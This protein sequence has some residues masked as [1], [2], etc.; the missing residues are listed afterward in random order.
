VG[1]SRPEGHGEA[2]VKT[3]LLTR[4]V[5]GRLFRHYLLFAAIALVVVSAVQFLENRDGLLD[6]PGTTLLDVLRHALLAAPGLFS[7]LAGFIALVSTL[8]ALVTLADHGELRTMLTSGLGY[9]ALLRAATPAALA[10]AGLHTAVDN[11]A[12]P[13]AA[14]AL[15]D[16]GIEQ[17]LAGD[18]G[19]IW[20]RE[21]DRVLVAE[22][23]VAHD[24]SLR[25]VELFV[26]DDDGHVT[27]RIAGPEARVQHGRLLFPGATRT[28][29][30]E[31]GRA[32]RDVAVP[33]AIGFD[34]LAALS[35]EPRR[36]SAWAIGRVLEQSTAWTHPRHV[37]VLWLHRKLAAPV[38][39]GLAALLLAPL[40]GPAV[41]WGGVRLLLAGVAAGFL[42]FVADA[43]LMG[44]GEAGAL[45]PAAAAWGLPLLLGLAVVSPALMA[46]GVSPARG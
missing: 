24:R 19:A 32:A 1:G 44:L 40:A 3:R 29:P 2:L 7:L 37:H 23:L 46:R 30:G 22:R 45:S 12:L 26:L 20:V 21:G 18:V 9:G 33:L 42:A 4:Y 8:A 5:S 35:I 17:R 10:M 38:G 28:R 31:H 13:V 34:T 36:S 25:G 41:R 27:E 43:L 15:R 6:R 16:W 11:V 39:S 14:A